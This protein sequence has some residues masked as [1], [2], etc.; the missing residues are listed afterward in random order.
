MNPVRHVALLLYLSYTSV[1]I[2]CIGLLKGAP[3]GSLHVISYLLT[4]LHWSVLKHLNGNGK[5]ISSR[6]NLLL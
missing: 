3:L 4:W 6:L 1:N 2:G 5:S